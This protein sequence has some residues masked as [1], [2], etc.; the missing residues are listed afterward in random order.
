[1]SY[2]APH[3]FRWAGL[4]TMGWDEMGLGGKIDEADWKCV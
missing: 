4:D 1:M 2:R 3:D